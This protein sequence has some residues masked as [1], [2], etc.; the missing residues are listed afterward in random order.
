ML[1][2]VLMGKWSDDSAGPRG[3]H[4]LSVGGDAKIS[5]LKWMDNKYVLFM[6]SVHALKPND[7]CRR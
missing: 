7:E 3:S 2:V 5:C 4:H 1:I 6:S